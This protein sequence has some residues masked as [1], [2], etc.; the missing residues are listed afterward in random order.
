MLSHSAT[1]NRCNLL[2]PF[3][4]RSSTFAKVILTEKHNY[5]SLFSKRNRYNNFPN[6]YFNKLF[7]GSFCLYYYLLFR[8]KYANKKKRK[9]NRTTQ[10]GSN[11]NERINL[12]VELI[13]FNVELITK[14][15]SNNEE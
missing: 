13:Y 2:F 9:E 4:Y 1:S 11:R 14:F 5:S 12:R 7:Q 15:I 6:Y 3:D 10:M 8:Q